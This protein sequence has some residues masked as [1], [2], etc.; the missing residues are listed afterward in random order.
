MKKMQPQFIQRYTVKIK[1]SVFFPQ[2]LKYQGLSTVC[3][4]GHIYYIL[5]INP[6]HKQ[7]KLHRQ[8]VLNTFSIAAD[9]CLYCSKTL[10]V[11]TVFS[12][13][14]LLETMTEICCNNLRSM[15]S[16]PEETATNKHLKEPLKAKTI[17]SLL[18]SPNYWHES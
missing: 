3:V 8:H 4:P 14:C 17:V 7:Q 5:M 11:I 16:P 2:S 15:F 10:Y 1:L 18:A 13:E 9:L 12:E 6:Q